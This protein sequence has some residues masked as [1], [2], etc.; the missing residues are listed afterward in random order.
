MLRRAT[1]VQHTARV[2][3]SACEEALAAQRLRSLNVSAPQSLALRQDVGFESDACLVDPAQT[4]VC[5]SLSL[6]ELAVKSSFSELADPFLAGVPPTQSNGHRGE[7]PWLAQ[8]IS[9]GFE[10]AGGALR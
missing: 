6:L 3:T 1:G 2:G 10:G 7:L 5:R 8:R 4:G 9:T